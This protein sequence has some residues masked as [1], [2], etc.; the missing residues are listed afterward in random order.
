MLFPGK[1]PWTCNTASGECVLPFVEPGGGT[2]D[3]KTC[4]STISSKGNGWCPTKATWTHGGESK[5][6]GGDNGWDF[7]DPKDAGL[8][9]KKDE[10]FGCTYGKCQIIK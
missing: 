9:L 10:P 3:F 6:S 4:E 7:C 5:Y 8:E 1:S 2:V